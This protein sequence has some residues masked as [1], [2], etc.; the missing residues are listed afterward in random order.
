VHAYLQRAHD[1]LQDA[2]ARLTLEQLTVRPQGK[3][4]IAEIL[5][6]LSRAFSFSAAGARRAMSAHAASSRR[7][8]PRQRFR[9]FVVIGC[10]YLPTGVESPKMVL[11][12]GIDPATALPVVMETLQDMNAALD[13]AALQFGTHVKLMDHPILGPLSIDEW[14]RFHWIHTRHHVRQIRAR[15]ARG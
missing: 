8:T 10:G 12:V 6:H 15:V 3:W 9:A 11:P 7:P 14:R 5:E 2:S 13:A 4:T 1:A